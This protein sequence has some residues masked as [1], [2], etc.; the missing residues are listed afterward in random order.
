MENI[1]QVNLTTPESKKKFFNL[2]IAINQYP[3]SIEF[4]KGKKPEQVN[5]L[6]EFLL[7]S[8]DTSLSDRDINDFIKVVR[9]FEELIKNNELNRTFCIFVKAII[10]GIMNDNKIGRSLNNYI[11]KYNF[12]EKLFTQY[13][14]N[15]EGC[16]KKI[17]NILNESKYTIQLNKNNVYSLEGS[18]LSSFTMNEYQVNNENAN[19]DEDINILGKKKSF[20][21]QFDFISYSDLEYIFQ[22]I[23]IAKI[24]EKYKENADKFIY[25]FKNIKELLIILNELYRKGY[26]D[27]FTISISCKDSN[28]SCD[29]Q[30]KTNLKIEDMMKEFYELKNFVYK[31]LNVLYRNEEISRFFY[32]RQLFLI[33]NNIINNQNEIKK[34]DLFKVAFNNA[35]NIKQVLK[36]DL[37]NTDLDQSEGKGKFMFIIWKMIDYLNMQLSFNNLKINDIYKLNEIQIKEPKQINNNENKQKEKKDEYKGIY[38]YSSFKNQE[39]ESLSIYKYMTKNLPINSCFLYCNKET[40]LE[41]LTSFITRC[42]LCKYKVLFC[43]VNVNL[44]NNRIRSYFLNIIKKTSKMNGKKMNSCLIIIFSGKDDDMHKILLKTENIQ[45]FP[46]ISI[47]SHNFSFDEEFLD[48]YKIEIIKSNNCGLGKSELIKSQKEKEIMKKEKGKINYIYFPLGGQFTRQNLINRI[49]SLP[50]MSDNK[51]NFTIH[52]DITQTKEIELLNEFFFKLIVLRKWDLNENVKYFGKNVEII[53]EVP[54]DYKDYLKEIQILSKLKI[55]NIEKINKINLSPELTLVAKILTMYKSEDILKS[56]IDKIKLKLSQ[57]ECQNIILEYLSNIDVKNPNYF[58]INSFI[59][60]LNDEFLKFSNCEGYKVESLVTNAIAKG[61]NQKDISDIKNLRKFII[62]SLVQVTKLF[63]IGPYEKLIKS[64]EINQNIINSNDE[65]K[66]QLINKEL[67]IEISSVSFDIIKPSLVVFNEDGGSCTIITTCKESDIEFKNLEKLYNSQNI[68]VER[69]RSFR[70]LNKDE[71]LEYLLRFI[72]V[73]LN[74]KQK[75]LG[76]YVYTPDN[77]IKVV[78]IHLRLRVK[79]PVIMMGET[80]CGKTTLI[81]MASKLINKGKIYIKKMNIHAGITD[82]DIIKFMEQTKQEVDNEDKII[83]KNRKKEFDNQTEENKRAY[84]KTRSIEKIYAEYEEQIKK[85]KIWIFFDEINTC[86]SMGLLIEIFCKNSIYGKELDNRFIYI[87]ACNPYRISKKENKVFNILYKKQHK[88]KN[89]VYTVNPLPISLLNFVF[90]FGSLKENDELEYIKSMVY[91]TI[92]ELIENL[93]DKNL[94][95]EKDNII[96][97]AKVSVELCQKNMKKNNDISIVSLREVNRFNVFVRFF[98][99]YL[100]KR[101]NCK[102]PFEEDKIINYYKS[103]T[104][105]EIFYCAIN[106]SLFICYYLRLPDKDSRKELENSLNKKQF[107]SDG[108]FLKIPIMEENYMLN[109]FDIPRGIA[110]NRNLK[111]NIFILFFCIINKI[112]LITCGKPGRSKTL[113]FQII[114]NSMKGEA[115]KTIFCRKYPELMT[116]QIQGS[117]NTTSSEILEIFKKGR[118]YKK[119]NLN[120]IVVIFMD[121]MGLAEISENN[122]LKVMHSELEQ[123]NDKVSFVGISNWF[124]DAS[125]MN[126]VIYNVVQDPDE[127]DIIETGEEIAKSYEINGENYSQRYGDIILRLSKAYYKYI[128]KKKNE[129]DKDQYFHGSRDFYSLIKSVLNDI[130]KNINLIDKYDNE[131]EDDEKNKLLNNICINQIMRNFGGLEKSIDEF[132]SYFFEGYKN[133]AYLNN[134]KHNIN[135]N[136][137]KCIQDNIYDNESRYLLLFIDSY[138]SQELLDYIL[139]EIN[140]KNKLIND[141]NNIINNEKKEKDGIEIF[142]KKNLRREVVKKYYIGSKF[143]ADKNNITY[144]NQILNRIKYQ[145]ETNNILILKD[146]ESVYP[147]LYELF[148]QSFKYLNGKKFVHLGQSK[149]LS[150]V[151]DNFKIIVLVEKSQIINQEPPFLNRFEKHIINFSYLLNSELLSLSEE[152]YENLQEINKIKLKYN[153]NNNKDEINIEKKFKKYLDFI[154]EEEIKGLVYIASK[155]INKDINDENQNSKKNIIIQSV[156][157]KI[158]PC[159]T[160]EL[161]ILFSKYEFRNKYNFYFNCIYEAYKEKYCYNMKNYL[162]KLNNDISIVYTFSSFFDDIIIDEKEKIIGVSNIQF[163][164]ETTT[165]ININSFSTM[166]HL[167]KVIINFIFKET[168][169]DDKSAE[170]NLLIL[171]FKEEDLIKLNDIYYLINDYKTNSKK[172]ILYRQSKIFIF[173]I[174]LQ[175][176]KNNTYNN[177]ISFL[178]NCPQI[179]IKNFNNSYK[180]FPKILISSNKEIIQKHLLDINSIIDNHIDEVLR[181][182]DYNLLNFDNLSIL[183]TIHFKPTISFYIKNNN[184]LK[185]I[186]I[187]CLINLINNDDDFIIKIFEE[188]IIKNDKKQE[189]NLMPLLFNNF[190]A[191][192]Q[193]ELRKIILFIEKEQI[194][195]TIGSNEILSKNE[196]IQKYINDFISKINNSENN[197][198][199]WESKN[200]NQKI[201]IEVLLEQKLPFC[202]K[203]LMSLFDYSQKNIANKYLEEDSYFLNI[204]IKE[205]NIDN[206]LNKYMNELKKM[207]DNLKIELSKYKI[208]IDILNSKDEDLISN[209]FEDCFFIFCQKNKK[210]ISRYSRLSKLLNLI[211]QLRLKTR[212]N[213]ELNINFIKKEKIDLFPSFMDLIKEEDKKY[214]NNDNK[215]KNIYIDKFVSIINFL[216]S[217]SKE[218]YNI[219]E[220]YDFLLLNIESLYEKI[221]IIIKDKKVEIEED[222]KRNPYYC[223]IN[224]IPFFY[225]IESLCKILKE[226][227]VDMIKNKDNNLYSK[228][229]DILKNVNYYL[230]NI[231]KLERR[232]LLFSKEVFSLEIIIKIISQIQLKNKDNDFIKLSIETTLS[233]FV[234]NLDKDKIVQILKKQNNILITLFNDNLDE[235]SKL[236]NRIIANLFKSISNIEIRESILKDFF[237]DTKM[238]YNNKLMKYSYSLMKL[239]NRFILL[240][241]PQTEKEKQKF[242][243][244]FNKNDESTKKLINNSNNS[245]LNEII[246]YRFEIICDTYFKKILND[247]KNKALY[248]KLCGKI[249]KFYLEES[250]KYFYFYDNNMQNIYLN[251]FFKL[252]CIAYIKR[253]L[254][255]YI[256]ILYNKEKYQKF[257][258]REEVNSILFSC[259][260]D[261]H[262]KIILYYCLKLLLK[263]SKNWENFIKYYNENEN[264]E[265]DILG[266]KSNNIFI[267]LKEEEESL[268]IKPILLLDSKKALNLEYNDLLSKGD[269]NEK[270]KKKFND[271]FLITNSYDYLYTF[272]SNILILYYSNKNNEKKEKYKKLILLI[273]QELN[274][275]N[276]IPDKNILSFINLFFELN[277]FNEKIIPK[278]SI[279]EIEKENISK[280]IMLLYGLRFVFS[281]LTH[282]KYNSPDDQG[283]YLDLL[284][285]KI[286]SVIDTSFI[287]GNFPYTSL[288]IQSFYEI[289]NKL[290]DNPN[291]IGVYLCSCGYNYTI[292]KYTF[293]TKVSKCPIC[294]KKIGGTNYILVKRE[295]HIRIFYDEESRN[296]KL[297]QNYADKNISNKLLSELEK[298]INI[299]KEKLEKGME[300]CE[301]DFFLKD[302][303]K[304]RDMNEITFRFLNFVFYSFLFYSNIQGYIKD[305]NLSKYLIK[306]MTCF[307]IMVENWKKINSISENIPVEIFINLIYDEVIQQFINCPILKTKEDA[308]KFEK[309]VNEIIINKIKDNNLIEDL[310]KKNNDLINISPNS[311]KSIIQEI[312][313]YKIY[314]EKDFPQF[315]YFYLSEFPEKEHFILKF[316]SK[317]NNKTKFPILNTIINNNALKEKL[318]L[319]KY[320]PQINELCNYMINYV[321]FKY[322]REDAKKILI[323]EEINDEKKIK[324]LEDFI[325]KYREIR[326]FIKKQGKYEFGDLF[327]DLENNLYLSNLCVDSGELGFGLVLLAM[328]EEMAKWQNSFID[329]VV[330]SSNENLKYYKDL[331]NSKIMIQD[332]E[333][334][335][336]LNLPS[337]DFNIK[338]KREKNNNIDNF[339]ILSIILDSS[340]RK[341]N[342][343][344]YNFD[345]IED[346]LASYILPKIKYFKLEFRKVIYQYEFY[347]GDRNNIIINFMQKYQQRDLDDKELKSVVNY[348]LEEKKK[349]NFDIINLLFSLQVLIDVILEYNPDID[350]TLY[351]FIENNEKINIPNVESIKDFFIQMNENMQKDGYTISDI[352]NCFTIN[353][354]ISL[355]DIV[356]LF[357]WETIKNNL[358]KKYLEDINRNNKLQ[359][360][361]YYN[362]IIE[363]DNDILITRIDLCAAIR[364]FITRY[365][366]GK[367]DENLKANKNLKNY[368]INKELWPIN[369]PEDYII[370]DEINKIFGKE[371]I[372]LSQAEKLYEY[373]GGDISKLDEIIQKYAKKEKKKPDDKDIKNDENEYFKKILENNNNEDNN[374]NEEKKDE[375]EKKS[376]EEDQGEEHNEGEVEEEEEPQNEEITY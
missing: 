301:K 180:N 277:N 222:E 221:E 92:N 147:A 223:K 27:I 151:E 164:K 332:C 279:F 269:L 267:N 375:D 241:P 64:E 319:M 43:I 376:N 294:K 284:T 174:Y 172:K 214:K 299:E 35:F 236:M 114:Q 191:L 160:E 286:S 285:K 96:N 323:K 218:I 119:N 146:L 99:D 260:D 168:R 264:D 148:N 354:L 116:F 270:D 226:Q 124:I 292:E 40:S 135:Y 321:S 93:K 58:Q 215:E 220:L 239:I 205:E 68:S 9:F 112:P 1:F 188:E 128:S 137:M 129:N 126:R 145:M 362:N 248:S 327:T 237:L 167:E 70:K 82:E 298:E 53:I 120:K 343:V 339:D 350:I 304:I 34:L 196:I 65:E 268:I 360:D 142:N 143:K 194:I 274:I 149:S 22:R 318:K 37:V 50:D 216:Q 306:S 246:L 74:D 140:E 310:N 90:N 98:L 171:K 150:L 204:R 278:M 48:N 316:N 297:K 261:M 136:V 243:D 361:N 86:N 101:K 14:N 26:Q 340:Y 331:Y 182:F 36:E 266:I 235:Y 79:I 347:V 229:N 342:K 4:L 60:I 256:D 227:L 312:F 178:L 206:E 242:I 75:I 16:I 163:S 185:D 296:Q 337:L 139:E 198:F 73:K 202:G 311:L 88:K 17:K 55:K 183:K 3:K 325:S 11:E 67:N 280:I 33:Y 193:N 313:P 351:S 281:L 12:I 123:E 353:S 334:E 265:V 230:Q 272:L 207:D 275:G 13:L 100:M 232:F 156:L 78:L 195:Y 162:E 6:S 32:G 144:S 81:E 38:F 134:L 5:N 131:K 315:K 309:T 211:I 289:K 94:F 83:L 31:Q 154:K 228:E 155:K 57:E 247:K 257:A 210:L 97:I 80:G 169:N 125:K 366:S 15:T 54:N 110:K 109:N 233:L 338:I 141:N 263:L 186:L 190:N 152:I 95:D 71:I 302:N 317:E 118:E 225:I 258:E 159:F 104:L 369:Y 287:P 219:L 184:I 19:Q 201:T 107:F 61:M 254:F 346:E 322:S 373:L 209:L 290:K 259:Q 66:S 122:P 133:I 173:V 179:M 348:I 250:I 358:D 21:A 295:G 7:E 276:K 105:I 357:S 329:T 335:N 132:K 10:D 87:G 158:A 166:E 47:L 25:Y 293:P 224:K 72:N 130:M 192:I 20:T 330:E 365:L 283:F 314:P 252:Y 245:I 240:E 176:K 238:T 244:N 111:E 108:D 56:E 138:L 231:L 102:N 356:E 45:A 46:G 371:E 212:I 85:R 157:E 28:F 8:D 106:L 59:K 121:E 305:K 320:L 344:N 84:L 189:I 181:Y 251:N 2:F 23:Y 291:N 203:Y 367:I 271:L 336:I 197:K 368:L 52:F 77:F 127:E 175:N 115:S 89:L 91:G 255:Y 308:L 39:I 363:E 345:K 217:Y 200:I 30:D 177:Y 49:E 76:T 374:K 372:E 69:L 199:N 349:N 24:P 165:E 341:G 234:K 41:E 161:M 307:E 62:K 187:K 170:K 352:D 113:S 300:P 117:L 253:Y 355:I 208:I 303:E 326:P 262:K 288:K 44:L 29:Y 18:Y 370:E 103:K 42:K 333:E 273:N 63:L 364:K 359:F 282:L 324:L 51:K 328:Y 153:N 213:N 249:S